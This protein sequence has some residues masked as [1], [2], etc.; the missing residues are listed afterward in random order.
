MP[1][2]TPSANAI[3]CSHCKTL[4]AN[5]AHFC[6]HCGMPLDGTWSQSTGETNFVQGL[7]NL[8]RGLN[9]TMDV[10]ALL[11]RIG[12]SAEQMF[13][14]EASSIM[15][16][17]NDKS[18]LFFKVATGE[19]GGVVTRYKIKLGEGIAGWVAAKR[20]PVMVNDTSKDPRFTGQHDQASGF[21]TQSILCVPMLAGGELIG[22]IELL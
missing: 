16:L 18:H 19:Q 2:Q 8:A 3:A 7:L 14:C 10:D 15:L 12:Q 9:S 5:E 6:H 20:E 4:L 11:K 17:D 22:I 1:D 13:S 21:K